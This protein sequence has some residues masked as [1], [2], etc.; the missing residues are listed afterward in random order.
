MNLTPSLLI[1]IALLAIT[2]IT[3][4]VLMGIDKHR[5][6]EGQRRL[7]ETTLFLWA[8]MFGALGGTLGMWIF[9]HKTRHPSFFNGFPTM[10]VVQG[11]MLYMAL[12]MQPPF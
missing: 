6:R 3:A 12:N 10:A 4:F 8:G 11:V 2:N 1:L 9:R 5:A 7:H